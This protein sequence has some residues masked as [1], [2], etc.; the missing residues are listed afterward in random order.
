METGDKLAKAIHA[1]GPLPNEDP[2]SP[3]NKA[4]YAAMTWT[5]PTCSQPVEPSFHHVGPLGWRW[6]KVACPRCPNPVDVERERLAAEQVIRERDARLA[7]YR[8]NFPESDM[9]ERLKRA[10]FDAW[11]EREGTANAY[12]RA[13]H[14][15]QFLVEPDPVKR[16]ERY[17]DRKTDPDTVPGLSLFGTKGNGKS[18]LAAAIAHA[19]RALGQAVAWVH[20]PAF[21]LKLQ[22][23]SPE[24]RADLLL[25]AAN[26]DLLVL[27]EFG[28]GKLTAAGIGWLLQ[29]VDHRYR[30]LAPLVLTH[31]ADPDVLLDILRNAAAT[32]EEIDDTDAERIMDRLD[33]HCRYVGVT[34]E[35]YRQDAAQ[36]RRRREIERG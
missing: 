13:R 16:A 10:T 20:V 35:S 4:L 17:G 8:R 21:L 14:L 25:L 28:G 3:E 12:K 19:A 32:G 26:A 27:D 23:A 36:E 15:M 2:D 11:V 34:A 30:H 18:H 1:S 33:E 29:L 7:I 9:G 24:E 6:C 5:C 31:N 22:G